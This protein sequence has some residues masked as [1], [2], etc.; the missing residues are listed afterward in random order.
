MKL[1]WAG[2]ELKLILMKVKLDPFPETYTLSLVALY[3]YNKREA[4]KV[5][6]PNSLSAGHAV[7]AN[8]VVVVATLVQGR[9]AIMA[10]SSRTYLPRRR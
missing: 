8:A 2:W 6:M 5:D 10:L 3:R 9:K 4:S 1:L 7:A